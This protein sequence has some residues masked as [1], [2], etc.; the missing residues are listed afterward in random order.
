MRRAWI[1]SGLGLVMVVLCLGWQ[2]SYA[3]EIRRCM[4]GEMLALCAGP[5][6][7]W[8]MPATIALGVALAA[9][10]GWR[11]ASSARP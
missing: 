1:A 5:L 10:G 3:D 7:D 2:V 11:L 6:P 9:I 4:S 8:L